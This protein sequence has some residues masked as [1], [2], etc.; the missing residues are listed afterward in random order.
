MINSISTLLTI[1]DCDTAIARAEDKRLQIEFE[2]FELNQDNKKASIDGPSY[3][4]TLQDTQDKV[5]GLTLTIGNM[6][7]GRAKTSLQNELKKYELK[8]TNLLN[9]QGNY[10]QQ[11]MLD[12]QRDHM[13]LGTAL[14]GIDEFVALVQARKAEL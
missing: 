7:D 8:L 6:P 4:N 10:G 9:K 14:T 1:A 13:S 11:S 12:Q 5:D 2:R 3:E